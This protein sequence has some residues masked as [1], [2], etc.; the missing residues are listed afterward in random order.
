LDDAALRE[1]FI[2]RLYTYQRWLSL[3]AA[4]LSAQRLLEF[5]AR[6]KYLFMAHSP[7]ACRHLG[8]LLSNRKDA[9]DLWTLAKDYLAGLTMGLMQG[10]GAS[11]HFNVLQHILVQLERHIAPADRAELLDMLETYR[12]GEIPL[13]VPVRCL[14]RHFHCHADESIGMQ[15]YLWPY[16]DELGL[17]N[18]L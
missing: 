9:A 2:C 10:G 16:P 12:R 13:A 6:H 17:R 1:N 5:H 3:C 4:G 8:R 18:H 15:C 7:D 11:M 14:R